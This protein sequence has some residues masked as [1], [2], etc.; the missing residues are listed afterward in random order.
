MTQKVGQFR[1]HIAELVQEL[2]DVNELVLSRLRQGFESPWGY[3]HLTGAR[4]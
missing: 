3:K 4:A 2:P 1:K